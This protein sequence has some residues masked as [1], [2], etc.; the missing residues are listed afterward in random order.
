MSDGFTRVH[1]LAL[2]FLRDGDLPRLLDG[3]LAEALA[4]TGADRGCVQILHDAGGGMRLGAQH[5]LVRPFLEY[6]ANLRAPLGG[7]TVTAGDRHVRFDDVATSAALAGGPDREALLAAQVRALHAIPLRTLDGRVVGV[8]SAL[9]RDT[10]RPQPAAIEAL[11]RI[12]DLCA[13]GIARVPGA[14]DLAP[15]TTDGD[16]A[17]R[18]RDTLQLFRNTVEN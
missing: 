9:H 5:G 15:A 2:Q 3:T 14:T 12:A 7:N 6:V 1:A 8:L 13:A 4:I 16:V 10:P 18:L 11:D 17:A